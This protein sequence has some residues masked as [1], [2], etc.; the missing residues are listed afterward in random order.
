[1]VAIIDIPF[2]PVLHLG[3]LPIHWY[4][5]AYVLAFMV[6]MQIATPFLRSHGLSEKT[7]SS[8]FWWNIAIGLVGARLYYVIQQPDLGAFA[9][10]PIRI[11]AVWQGGMA[12][13][14]AVMACLLTTAVLAYRRRL[15]VW[16]LLDAGALFA[17]LPQAIGRLGN[18]VNGD[19]LGAPSNLPWAVRYTN[20]HTFAPSTTTAFQPANAYELLTS[21]ALFALVLWIL[22]RRPRAGTAGI[23][24]VAGYAISQVLVFFTRSTEPVLLFGL[25]QAQLTAIGVLLI[26]VPLLVLAWTRYPHA[27]D[28]PRRDRNDHE[29]PE[30]RVVAAAR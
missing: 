3:P 16:V 14:G 1:M 15:P 21:L 7:A 28:D 22:S 12:F 13:F 29:A 6:G 2:D 4:G 10:N 23:V 9:R 27:W 20:A 5:V 8:L 17:T 11:I 26:G 30:V 25:K 24:Y 18:I 19:I